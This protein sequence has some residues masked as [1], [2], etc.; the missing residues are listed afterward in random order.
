MRVNLVGAVETASAVIP[1][2]LSAGA[3]HFVALSSLGDGV[4]PE[5]PSYAAS[6][7]GLSSYL[8]G[9]ALRLRSRG[10]RVTNVR[11]GFVDTKMAKSP[12]RPMMMSVERATDIVMESLTRR[13]ARWSAP[14]PMALLMFALRC[15]T[16]VRLWLA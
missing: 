13:S 8:G 10:V 2:M 6:K 4:S 1:P 15:V 16:A 12:V 11:L 14:A 5:A 7:A 9:L 3:G